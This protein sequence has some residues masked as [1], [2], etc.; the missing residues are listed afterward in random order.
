MNSHFD[1]IIVGAGPVGLCLALSLSHSKKSILILDKKEELDRHS[2]APVIWPKTS[3]ILNDLGVIDTFLEQGEVVSPIR[4]WNADVRPEKVLLSLPLNDLSS[5]TKFPFLLVLP[6]QKTEQII[7]D[8][9]LKTKNATVKF[10]SELLSLSQ[11]HEE[12]EITFAE[13]LETKKAKASFLVG[14]DGAHSKVRELLGFTLDGLTYTLKATLA[15]VELVNK[16]DY[17]FPRVST[18][19]FPAFCI[20]LGP[21]LWRLILPYS[22]KVEINI[23]ERIN[24][25]VEALFDQEKFHTIWKSEF[26]LHRRMSNHFHKERVVLAGD[27]AH[28]NSPVGGQGMN[29]GIQDTQILHQA[30]INALDN[31]STQYLEKYAQIRQKEIQL[32]V[33][34]FTNTLTKILSFNHGKYIQLILKLI[35]EALKI[36]PLK[37]HILLRLSMLK[38]KN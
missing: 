16:K 36:T 15:D 13:G 25:A 17:K 12:V 31:N 30:L 34:Q 6:Q 37:N 11:N 21:K 5:Q 23:E 32:G 18:K 29:A 35:N 20:K 19:Y 26:K 14:C 27:A 7:L 24:Q 33:N 2:R 38:K 1:V 9:L 4:I 8:E 28:L 3:E 10:S 22:D